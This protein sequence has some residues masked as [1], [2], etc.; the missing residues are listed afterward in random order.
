VICYELADGARYTDDA[1]DQCIDPTGAAVEAM[2]TANVDGEEERW[3]ENKKLNNGYPSAS[4]KRHDV[5][6]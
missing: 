3:D 1:K 2:L 6:Q 5:Y 4:V